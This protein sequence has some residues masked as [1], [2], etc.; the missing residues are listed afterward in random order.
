MVW[1]QEKK[2]VYEALKFSE[3][4]IWFNK[5]IKSN[6]KTINLIFKQNL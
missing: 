1:N 4:W 5:Q 2:I 6:L 3:N